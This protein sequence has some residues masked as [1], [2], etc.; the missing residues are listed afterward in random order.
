MA[1][2]TASTSDK[3]TFQNFSAMV[4]KER[5][6]LDEKKRLE[7]E[8]KCLHQLFSLLTLTSTATSASNF[9]AQAAAN[10]I[11]DKKDKIAITVSFNMNNTLYTLTNMYHRTMS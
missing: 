8:V 3:Q 2:T 6:L 5:E 11:A 1:T 4:Q 10:L 7:D 9:T